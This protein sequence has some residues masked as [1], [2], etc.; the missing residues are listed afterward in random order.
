M[1][2]IKRT[3]LVMISILLVNHVARSD[4]DWFINCLG[5]LFMNSVLHC[6]A[7]RSRETEIRYSIHALEIFS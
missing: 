7:S 5:K 4:W 3:I 6:T 1:K 2:N